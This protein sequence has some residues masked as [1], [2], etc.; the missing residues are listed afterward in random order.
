MKNK[1]NIFMLFSVLSAGALLSSCSQTC[2]E[3]EECPDPIVCP[4]PE[5]CP[6]PVVCP[7]P[8]KTSFA[9]STKEDVGSKITIL[10]TPGE[11]GFKAGSEVKF[12]ALATSEQFDVSSVLVDGKVVLGNNGEFTFTMPNKD[13][14]IETKTTVLGASDVNNISTFTDEEIAELPETGAE[15]VEFLDSK[16]SANA[17][18]FKE[19]TF[20]E[21]SDSDSTYTDYYDLKIKAGAN[22]ILKVDGYYYSLGDDFR[23]TYNI[24]RGLV[25]N[26]YFELKSTGSSSG[27]SDSF[28]LY[29]TS[30]EEEL[31]SGEI[32]LADAENDVKFFNVF[33]I[34]ADD[35]LTGYGFYFED[36]E[37]TSTFSSDKTSVTLKI[38]DNYIPSD[39]YSDGHVADVTIVMDG[40]FF[41]N[42]ITVVDK[43]YDFEF[44]TED[45][46]LMEDAVPFETNTTEY[47]ATRGYKSVLESDVDLNDYVMSNYDLVTRCYVGNKS[48]YTTNDGT[49]YTG[50]TLSFRFN[51]K[52]FNKALVI[53]TLI[54]CDEGEDEIVKV[55][56]NTATVLKTGTFHLTFDNGL[57]E[58]KRFEFVAATPLPQSISVELD[59]EQMFAGDTAKLTAKVSPNDASQDVTVTKADDSVDCTITKEEDGTFT[60]GGTTAGTIKLLVASATDPTIITEVEID[61][62]EKPNYDGIYETITTKSLY[63]NDSG[64]KYYIN[65]NVDGTGELY[66]EYYGSVDFTTFKWTLDK[67]TL[68]FTITDVGGSGATLSAISALTTTTF[69]VT[70]SYYGKDTTKV[71]EATDRYVY[72][73]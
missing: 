28:K 4:K 6:E 67:D 12:T 36:A 71:F 29:K 25:D 65:F 9:I 58:T 73:E 21:N 41:V 53:P 13:V 56:G 44:Y 68:A 10:T 70:Y 40:D 20:V 45:G 34:I 33:D 2:P 52:D 46:T 42:S 15:L 55:E 61:V 48:F 59:K 62:L 32:A 47:I 1:K 30:S 27:E 5:E 3:P 50:G 69:N 66:D 37:V 31:S 22:D 49:V 39:S 8:E 64:E 18:F 23:Y 7:E 51:N 19:G 24:E 57:G 17:K 11:D 43:E 72:E 38:E 60:I 26:N 54:G 63:F 16:V 14:V 35:Y